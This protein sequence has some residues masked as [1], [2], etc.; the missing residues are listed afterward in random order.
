M[1]IKDLVLNLLNGEEISDI[2][3]CNSSTN[4]YIF[5]GIYKILAIDKKITSIPI[6]YTKI[7][8]CQMSE[9]KTARDILN[10]KES[11]FINLLQQFYRRN[12][13][14]RIKGD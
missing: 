12:L 14:K 7:Y 9:I 8:N 6:L 11:I 13:I 5:E 3:G 4:G 10:I 1:K 2:F